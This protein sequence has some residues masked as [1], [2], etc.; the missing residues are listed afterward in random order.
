MKCASYDTKYCNTRHGQSR[1]ASEASRPSVQDRKS[2]PGEY[3]TPSSF[4]EPFSPGTLMA[5]CQLVPLSHGIGQAAK[6][7]LSALR[8]PTACRMCGVLLMAQ[9]CPQLS[10]LYQP[11]DPHTFNGPLLLV[12]SREIKIPDSLF[13]STRRST[14]RRG[15]RDRGLS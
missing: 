5:W 8:C 6:D 3:R 7:R 15:L 11:R 12:D 2:S 14:I 10:P 1:V 4:K 9:S 13:R